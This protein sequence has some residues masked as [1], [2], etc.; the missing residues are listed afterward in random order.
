[1]G[2]YLVSCASMQQCPVDETMRHVSSVG[3]TGPEGS[4]VLDVGAARLMLSSG[5]AL[6]I[7]SVTDPE[8]ELRKTRCKACGA[9]S[10]RTRKRDDDDDLLVLADCD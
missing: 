9:A 10:L 8:A 6:T 1:M 3:V 5:D 2:V 4:R 7:G